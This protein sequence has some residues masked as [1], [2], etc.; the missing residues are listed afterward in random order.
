MTAA[1]E[2]FGGTL[3]FVERTHVADVFIL[4]LI[5]LPVVDIGLVVFA[6]ND[7]EGLSEICESFFDAGF[8]SHFSLHW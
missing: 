3:P 1:Q 2:D 6:G 5:S 7:G 8:W 4:G